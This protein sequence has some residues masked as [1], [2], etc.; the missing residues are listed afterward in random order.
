M[1]VR[2]YDEAHCR[3][4][5]TG[6]HVREVKMPYACKLLVQELMACCVAF[7][8]RFDT[9]PTPA[10]TTTNSDAAGRSP[11]RQPQSS[12]SAVGDKVGSHDHGREYDH[13]HN[14]NDAG[15]DV[16]EC[17]VPRLQGAGP[18]GSVLAALPPPAI[19]G[20]LGRIETLLRAAGG[21]PN[22]RKR[23]DNDS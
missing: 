13:D 6:A 4:C 20:I 12:I 11:Y 5:N 3:V 8:F 2:G 21:A 19:D 16:D 10:A 17:V 18:G 14:D 22:K 9:S 1:A 23:D 7:R 15:D